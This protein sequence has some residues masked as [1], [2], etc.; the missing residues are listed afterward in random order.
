MEWIN[1]S[2]QTISFDLPNLTVTEKETDNMQ[3]KGADNIAVYNTLRNYADWATVAEL[4]ILT[5]GA[6]S[7]SVKKA[8]AT[9]ESENLIQQVEGK[10]HATHR[11]GG[12]VYL[13]RQ[14]AGHPDVETLR[15]AR[16]KWIPVLLYG[17]PGTGK[18]ALAHAAFGEGLVQISGDENTTPD[19]FLGQWYPTGKPGEYMW[20][21][22][23]LTVAMREGKVLFVDDITLIAPKALAALY[24]AMDGQGQVTIKTHIVDGSPEI[25]K[26][27]P[28]FYVVGA[29]NPGVHGAILTD[30]LSSRFTFQVYVDTDLTLA[31]KLG[32]PDKFIKLVSN[33]QT[34]QKA[35]TI[36]WVP[37]LR[38]L[39]AARDITA[40]FGEKTAVNNLI[41]LTPEEDRDVSVN[42][43][44]SVFGYRVMPL[45][46]GA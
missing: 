32:V 4:V 29:H 12:S 24:P 36:G 3:I 41:G 43:A 30:A 35:G 9:L 10:W 2:G 18:T 20:A 11:A 45:A 44:Q 13:P 40:S 8:L 38:E 6:T 19:D 16:A 28:G 1:G 34:K 37:Q 42:Q 15:I 46:V 22:G 23:P 7:G 26:A 21:D 39:L 5:P 27:K 17:P 25:V 33:L 31:S 14:L